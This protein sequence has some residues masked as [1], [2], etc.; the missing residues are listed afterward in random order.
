MTSPHLD[1]VRG[2]VA[3]VLVGLAPLAAAAAPDTPVGIFVGTPDGPQEV[4]VY[5]NRTPSGLRLGVGTLDEV[6]KVPG[7]IRLICNLPYWRVR[8]AY[9]A[10]ARILDDERA[11]RRALRLRT[12]RLTISAMLVQVMASEK[13]ADLQPLLAA[14]GATPENPA[15]VFVTLE[16]GG[17]V[18]DYI[19][20]VDPDQW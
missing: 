11:Q 20:A 16:S 13:P 18:R 8:S 17:M 15:Y 14:V 12:K 1:L 3:A 2:M 7:P 19:V 4:A 10:T 6:Q 5:A 9:L